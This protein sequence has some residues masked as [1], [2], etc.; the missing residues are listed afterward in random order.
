MV[1]KLLDKSFGVGKKP[2][3]TFKDNGNNGVLGG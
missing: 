3:E 1:L 2:R